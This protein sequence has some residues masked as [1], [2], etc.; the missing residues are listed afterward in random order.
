MIH[1]A[2]GTITEKIQYIHAYD[3]NDTSSRSKTHIPKFGSIPEPVVYLGN[4]VT[5][6]NTGAAGPKMRCY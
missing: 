2:R 3:M 5:T 1:L 4:K 6:W